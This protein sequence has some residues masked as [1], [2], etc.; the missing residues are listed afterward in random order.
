MP[1]RDLG[2]IIE[3]AAVGGWFC[4]ESRRYLS[5]NRGCGARP[6]GSTAV[7][8]DLAIVALPDS[9]GL[10]EGDDRRSMARDSSTAPADRKDNRASWGMVLSESRGQIRNRAGSAEGSRAKCRAKRNYWMMIMS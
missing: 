6:G 9:S 4:S 5:P 3:F 2:R 1:S 7:R 8:L 10:V